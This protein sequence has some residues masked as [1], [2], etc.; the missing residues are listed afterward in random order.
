MTSYGPRRAPGLSDTVL[1]GGGCDYT[2]KREVRRKATSKQIVIGGSRVPPCVK[3]ALSTL[4]GL[5]R[6]T[7]I[8]PAT[9]ARSSSTGAQP[10]S[11]DWR[12]PHLRRLVYF[13]G[14]S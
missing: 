10:I 12:S 8:E 6:E 4:R 1:A 3:R 14:T 2:E 7:K 11:A 5:E 9:P 13:F